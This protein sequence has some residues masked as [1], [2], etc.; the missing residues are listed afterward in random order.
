M[1]C[2]E[3]LKLGFDNLKVPSWVEFQILTPDLLYLTKILATYLLA[4]ST[5]VSSPYFE[6]TLAY[7]YRM[8]SIAA[9]IPLKR[10]LRIAL[11]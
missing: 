2:L 7:H 1:V 10:L 5:L 9:A 3:G 11:K 6:Q 8:A 4:K